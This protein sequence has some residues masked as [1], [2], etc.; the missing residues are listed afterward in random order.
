[1]SHRGVI[2]AVHAIHI[3]DVCMYVEDAIR[4][5]V[6]KDLLLK[7]KCQFE[8]PPRVSVATGAAKISHSVHSVQ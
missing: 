5:I 1:M 3:H 7:H 2:H 4:L 8:R 6:P